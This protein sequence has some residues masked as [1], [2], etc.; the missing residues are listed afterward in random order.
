[1]VATEVMLVGT[2]LV[3]KLNDIKVMLTMT[4]SL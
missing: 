1:M 2:I 4:A 3:C